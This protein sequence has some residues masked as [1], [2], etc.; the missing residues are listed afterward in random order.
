MRFQDRLRKVFVYKMLVLLGTARGAA[1][2]TTRD[3]LR[4]IR[5]R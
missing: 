3:S 2:L 1:E 4:F 5:G